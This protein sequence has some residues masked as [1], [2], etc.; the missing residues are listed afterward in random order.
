MI[1]RAVT[2]MLIISSDA[3]NMRSSVA[4]IVW[5]TIAPNTRIVTAAPQPSFT[6]RMI[7]A[8]FLAP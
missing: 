2:P 3:L 4:G 1:R 7:L 6:V 8:L 5:N